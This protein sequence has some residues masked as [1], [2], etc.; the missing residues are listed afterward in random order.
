MNL[1]RSALLTPV[2]VEVVEVPIPEMDGHVYIK[3]MT[4]TER[5]RFERQFRTRKGDTIDSRM[6]QLR[7]RI[8]IACVCDAEGSPILTDAD[9][10]ALGKQR[11]DIIERLVNAAQK[12]S[13]FSS[14]DMDELAAKN[15]N[16]TDA[17]S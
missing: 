13:G 1:D 3:G 4:V 7:Q 17:N 8:V 16:T 5:N 12:V 15:S 10:D 6:Q 11:A 9:I 2:A 14:E